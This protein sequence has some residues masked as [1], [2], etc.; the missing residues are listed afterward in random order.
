MAAELNLTT[1]MLELP[2]VPSFAELRRRP[3]EFFSQAREDVRGCVSAP[4]P[5]PCPGPAQRMRCG[6]APYPAALLAG[7][8]LAP[9]LGQ[10][11]ALAAQAAGGHA[12]SKSG[13][14]GDGLF[15]G[16]GCAPTAE[17][18]QPI[19]PPQDTPESTA[20][21][22]AATIHRVLQVLANLRCAALQDKCP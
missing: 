6:A 12:N 19:S 13:R 1:A 16:V 9:A 15:W 2:A 8:S 5:E 17:L 7:G 10:T 3:L 21:L 22:R 4:P 18:T 20:C 14:R 11:E